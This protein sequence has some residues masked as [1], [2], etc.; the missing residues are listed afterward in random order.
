M[1]KFITYDRS[2]STIT[3][4]DVLI[5]LLIISLASDSRNC[6]SLLEWRRAHGGVC[7]SSV[8]QV[9]QLQA[10]EL[11][12]WSLLAVSQNRLPLRLVLLHVEP[13]VTRLQE[14]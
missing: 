12:V 4:Q 9:Q 11:C 8:L 14:P 13:L 10:L 3:D 1:W 2:S 5:W 7:K 6:T